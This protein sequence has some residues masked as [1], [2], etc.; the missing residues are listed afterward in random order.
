MKVYLAHNFAAREWLRDVVKPMFEQM[1][2]V[3]TSSWV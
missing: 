3:V 2:H 1:G